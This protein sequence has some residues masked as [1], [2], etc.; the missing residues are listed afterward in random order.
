[1]TELLQTLN[2]VKQR[3]DRYSSNGINEQDTKATLLQPVLRSLGWDVEDLEDVQ[4]EYKIRKQDKPVDFALFL[5]RSPCLF[6]EAKGLGQNLD[7][8]KWANQIM[9]YAGVAGVGWVVLTDGNEYRLYNSHATVPI[10][11]KLFRSIKVA[12]DPIAACETLVLLSKNRMHENEIDTLWK[13]HFVDRQVQAAVCDLFSSTPDPSVIR[14][15]GKKVP[16]L[17]TKEVRAS[18][19]RASLSFNSPIKPN[20]DGEKV[21]G[22]QGKRRAKKP[23][24]KEKRR[25][26]ARRPFDL[27]VRA[28]DAVATLMR[29]GLLQSG[30]RISANYHGQLLQATITADGQVEFGSAKYKSPS[31]AGAAAKQSV[32]GKYMAT[33]GWDFW[34]YI[35]KSGARVPLSVARQQYLAKHPST[36]EP[37]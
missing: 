32:T 24:D 31:A 19:Q 20:T 25:R 12:D 10:E 34:H 6:V 21:I 9:G 30:M 16:G 17:S 22:G 29:G 4:R 3:V 11:E 35:D 1:M 14:L 18:L 33:D 8:R 27:G 15:I 28:G 37:N 13:A 2:R 36:D 5:L 23:V 7:D 26:A